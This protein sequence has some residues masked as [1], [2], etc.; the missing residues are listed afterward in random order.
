MVID[1]SGA[2]V[3][4][5]HDRESRALPQIRYVFLVGN[6]DNQNP[7]TRQALA[8][9]LVELVAQARDDISRHAGID[10]AGQFDEAGVDAEFPRFPGQVKW[11]Y[12]DAMAAKTRARVKRH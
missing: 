3:K 2:R 5:F 9:A 6:T 1:L 12:R 7:S 4:I 11:V 10:F 8:E